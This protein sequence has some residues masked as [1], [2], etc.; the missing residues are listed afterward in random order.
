MS[1]DTD[2]AAAHMMASGAR[3]RSS[4]IRHK[5][6]HRLP[7]PPRAVISHRVT[8]RFSTFVLS[9]FFFALFLACPFARAQNPPPILTPSAPPPPPGAQP[10]PDRRLKSDVELVVLHVTVADEKSGRAS[11]WG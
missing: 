11:C 6:C 1:S 5:A 4:Y 9:I 10:S 3:L 8:N 7:S 2:Q